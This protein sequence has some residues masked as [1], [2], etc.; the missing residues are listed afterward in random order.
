MDARDRIAERFKDKHIAPIGLQL[1]EVEFAPKRFFLT[2]FIVPVEKGFDEQFREYFGTDAIEVCRVP[3]NVNKEQ[4]ELFRKLA[5]TYLV[6]AL[7]AV[8]DIDPEDGEIR[9]VIDG[10]LH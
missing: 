5:Y 10:Q 8:F 3:A 9:T 4:E 2:A 7:K 6:D 1:R